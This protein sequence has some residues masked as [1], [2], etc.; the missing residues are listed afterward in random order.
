LV[1]TG[2]NVKGKFM[3]ASRSKRRPEDDNAAEVRGRILEAAFAAF[4]E[5]GYAAA[6]TLEIATRA[7]VSKRELYTLVGN[8][9]EMLTACITER[10]KRLQVPAELPVPRDRET[11]AHVLVSFGAQLIREVSD[12][13]VIAVFRLA[14][15]EAVHAPE[16]SQALNSI[17]RETSR[18]AL[19]N[20]MTQARASR[21]LDGHP[22]ELA[23]QFVG[24]LWSD[25]MVSLLLGVAARPNPREIA[26]RAQQAAAAFLQLHPPANDAAAPPTTGGTNGPSKD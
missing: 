4:T 7:R 2:T 20:I 10:S 14:I 11:L 8:K 9:Q 19:R 12:P 17:G 16:V 5:S 3:A 25:L 6:S 23:E 13:T 26:G 18:A 24:L 22:G 1:L 21:L 15:A